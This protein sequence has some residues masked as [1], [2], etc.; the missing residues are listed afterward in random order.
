MKKFTK[1]LA[2]IL[3]IAML[4]AVTVACGGKKES[5][6]AQVDSNQAENGQA[7]N[8]SGD[9]SSIKGEEQTWGEITVFVPEDMELNGGDMADKENKKAARL[10]AKDDAMKYINITVYEDDSNPK[11]NIDMTKS[12][13]KEY[14]PADV[15]YEKDGVTWTGVEYD[16]YGLH[17]VTV[18]A[19]VGSKVFYSM[20]AGYELKDDSNL[21]TVLGS[22]K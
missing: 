4:A 6:T 13:N 16:S 15:S 2:L 9:S 11:S 18:Y 21:P 22:L 19:T 3:A 17:C 10:L 14:N 20:S 1:I 7:D 5:D 8:G 12:M